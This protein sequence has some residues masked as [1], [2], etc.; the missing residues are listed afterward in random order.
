[1]KT[2][3]PQTDSELLNS[4]C[5]YN[6]G[7]SFML[8]STGQEVAFGN[9]GVVVLAKFARRLELE[10]IQLRKTLKGYGHDQAVLQQ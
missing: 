1:M 10:N 7:H 4:D 2:E 6:C 9:E 8:M 5:T 3:T